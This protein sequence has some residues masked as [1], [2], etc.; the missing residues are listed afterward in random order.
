MPYLQKDTT[1]L[2]IIQELKMYYKMYYIHFYYFAIR[3]GLEGPWGIW[4]WI[5]THRK[6]DSDPDPDLGVPKKCG[7]GFKADFVHLKSPSV[8][9]V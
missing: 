6:P 3:E 9:L 7:S 1:T 2:Q 4:N 8:L 5:Q